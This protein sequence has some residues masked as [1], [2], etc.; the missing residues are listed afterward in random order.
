MV[1]PTA[2]RILHLRRSEDFWRQID[3]PDDWSRSPADFRDQLALAIGKF[4]AQQP[5]DSDLHLPAFF[6]ALYPNR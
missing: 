4:Y 3:P 6:N 5:T 1:E 2:A